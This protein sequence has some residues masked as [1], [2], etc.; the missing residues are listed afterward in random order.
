M[1]KL[2][3]LCEVS[4]HRGVLVPPAE[5]TGFSNEV[6]ETDSGVGG[7]L[8]EISSEKGVRKASFTKPPSYQGRKKKNETAAVASR[9]GQCATRTEAEARTGATGSDLVILSMAILSL[10]FA[11]DV[12]R[13]VIPLL[14]PT[15]L[16]AYPAINFEL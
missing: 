13:C 3:P 2:R 15:T 12:P 14:T 16:I 10:L 11:V 9:V 5:W 7:G 4:L 8:R 1:A 6:R